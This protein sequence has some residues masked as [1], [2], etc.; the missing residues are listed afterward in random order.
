MHNV[1]IYMFGF[2]LSYKRIT[3]ISSAMM[4]SP[5]SRK[6]IPEIYSKLR[7]QFKIWHFL[8]HSQDFS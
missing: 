5:I 1:E 2:K 6:D 8:R 7:F 4:A 3:E